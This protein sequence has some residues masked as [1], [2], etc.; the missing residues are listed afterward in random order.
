MKQTLTQTT[1]AEERDGFRFRGGHNA[2][3]L[4]AT[5]QAR[6]KSTPRE[7]LKTPHDLARWL[8]AAGLASAPL[9]TTESDLALA[10]SLREAIYALA[11]AQLPDG[12]DAADAI[13]VLNAAAAKPSAA[14]QLTPGCA[15]TL[16]GPASALLASLARDAVRLFGGD[17]AGHIRQCQSP[18]CTLFFVDMSRAG[19]RRWCS[20][21]GCGNKAKVA[22]FRRRQR[23]A[24]PTKI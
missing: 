4:P 14:P 3:D 10:R 8:A 11:N 5:L 15:V 1:H 21:S 7:L 13:L 23:E 16:V 12:P 19:D 17:M 20:M 24:R 9:D 22:D 18:T 2:I 6:L